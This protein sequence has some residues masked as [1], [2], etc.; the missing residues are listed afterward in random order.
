MAYHEWSE[1]WYI[2]LSE[3][4]RTAVYVLGFSENYYCVCCFTIPN[5]IIIARIEVIKVGTRIN[6]IEGV[7][8]RY[9]WLLFHSVAS[10][11]KMLP[12]NADNAIR[13]FWRIQ[14]I[15]W[16]RFQ[17]R[18]I[19]VVLLASHWKQAFSIASLISVSPTDSVIMVMILLPSVCHATNG[20]YFW[21][22]TASDGSQT[23]D[24]HVEKPRLCFWPL[25]I[26]EVVALISWRRSLP[27]DE[28]CT[29]H[30][31]QLYCFVLELK[32]HLI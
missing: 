24:L 27:L 31:N 16:G 6:S 28:E 1:L 5:L 14:P 17:N 12:E 9:I 13:C 20:H 23:G 7:F 22:E 30:L 32:L 10:K 15:N 18:V 3:S 25:S 26:K 2:S 21:I 4:R 29:S 8:G 19:L 11:A